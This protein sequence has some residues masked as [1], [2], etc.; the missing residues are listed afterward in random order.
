[1]T[2]VQ[3][4][5]SRGLPENKSGC[6]TIGTNAPGTGDFE[7]R[8]NLLDAQ[9]NPITKKDLIRFLDALEHALESGSVQFFDTAVGGTNFVGPQI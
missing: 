8:Y 7:L 2:A 6:Y 4:S 5:S 3:I 9:N 1:M